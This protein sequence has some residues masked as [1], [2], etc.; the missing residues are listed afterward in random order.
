V[1]PAGSA[2]F[3]K[4]RTDRAVSAAYT[5]L[6]RDSLASTTFDALLRCVRACAPRFLEARLVGERQ[7]GVDAL[8]NLARVAKATPYVRPLVAWRGC[9]AS[10]RVAVDSLAQHLVSVYPVPRFLTAAWYAT[11]AYAEAKRRWFIAH[12][13]GASFRSLDLP[14]RLS[15]TMEHVFLAS[16]HHFSVEY[17]LRR[18]ELVGLGAEQRLLD[19]VLATRPALDLDNGPFWRT[20]WLFLI[21]HSGS[22]QESQVGPLIDFIHAVRH[23]RVA[24]ETG[25]GVVFREP[26]LPTF[27][28]KG[29]TVASV[30]RMM[31]RWH[32]DLAWVRGGLRWAPSQWRPLIVDIPSQDPSD[33]P[34]S[35]EM[36]ELTDSEQLRAEGT[37]LRHCVASYSHGC[38]RG[39]SRIWSLR[40]RRGSRVRSVATI[41]VRPATRTIVQARGFRNR[42]LTAREAQI[43][44]MWAAREKLSLAI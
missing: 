18:A 30:L 14:L 35:W 16:P 36:I 6:A 19:A 23:E 44:K 3:D 29:R 10:W 40:R 9:D 20:V 42:Y 43:V 11:D 41:E 13:S 1:S 2:R 15:R 5:G 8:V 28:M 12:A 38:W 33:I 21:A 25:T 39:A 24:V 17:A 31:E 32:R 26:P 34:A 27:T 37:A 7:P 4:R 22:I